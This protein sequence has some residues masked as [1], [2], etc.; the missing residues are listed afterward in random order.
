MTLPISP[1]T[2]SSVMRPSRSGTLISPSARHWRMSSTKMRARWRSARSSSCSPS[3]SAPSAAMCVPGEI[4]ASSTIPPRAC[5][6]VTTTS[7]PATTCSRSVEASS[8][9]LGVLRLLLGDEAVERLLAA[10]PDAHLLPGEHLV[11]GGERAPADRAGADDGEHLRVLPREPL[12]GD[13]RR[14][15]RAHHRVVRAVADG[16]RKAGLGVGVDQDREDGR[17]LELRVVLADRDP[18]AGGGGRVLDEGGHHLELAWIG[19]EDD[20]ALR[21]HVDATQPVHAERVLDAVV[22]LG[23]RQQPDHVRAAQDQRLAV[24]PALG[25]GRQL[26]RPRGASSRCSAST[27]SRK[28]RRAAPRRSSRTC[29]R[30]ADPPKPASAPRTRSSHA[31]SGTS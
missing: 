21:L 7:A 11:A 29:G 27:S 20:V 17:Q 6:P 8:S 26:L 10:A 24:S 22:V 23:R 3:R 2:S 4:H 9:K 1:A 14:G 19:V 25:H 15:A 5:V 31:C 12:R 13:R 30:A 28:P 16:E 18:L